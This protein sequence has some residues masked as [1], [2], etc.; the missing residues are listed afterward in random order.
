MEEAWIGAQ[1]EPPQLV[2]LEGGPVSNI[3]SIMVSH[4]I[5]THLAIGRPWLPLHL[6]WPKA[7]NAGLPHREQC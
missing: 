5:S 7:V 6:T 1:A 3:I 2:P 4:L